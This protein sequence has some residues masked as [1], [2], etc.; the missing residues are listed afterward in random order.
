MN[1]NP[2]ELIIFEEKEFRHCKD[3][4]GDAAYDTYVLKSPGKTLRFSKEGYEAIIVTAKFPHGFYGYGYHGSALR[5]QQQCYCHGQI[6]NK[7]FS[8]EFE[9]RCAAI[10][11]ILN[12][13][14][15][16]DWHRHF[17]RLQ[18]NDFVNPKTLF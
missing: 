15:P 2:G 4:D 8:N 17:I 12:N 5:G 11:Y 13:E 1:N 9:A 16:T 18:M 10:K 3:K 6:G 14:L 7:T